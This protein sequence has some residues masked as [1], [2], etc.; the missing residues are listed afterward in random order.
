[1]ELTAEQYEKIK[2]RLS[3]HR[4]NMRL[5]TCR[6]SMR[7]CLLPSNAANVAV[8]LLDLESG[9]A[10]IPHET[11]VEGRSPGQGLQEASARA[12]RADRY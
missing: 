3:V 6:C 1:M 2:D 12:V 10:S 9:T 4:R 8:F 11:L 5:Q 7:S